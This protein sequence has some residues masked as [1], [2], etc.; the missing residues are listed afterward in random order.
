MVIKKMI[1]LLFLVL[2]NVLNAQVEIL[3]SET[4]SP[5]IYS[6]VAIDSNNDVI[7][8]GSLGNTINI[9]KY[10]TLGELI[11]SNV[12]TNAYDI[13][14]IVT[15]VNNNIY[16]AVSSTSD[17]NIKVLKLTS[18]GEQEWL[19]ES[20]ESDYSWANDIAITINGDVIAI[21]SDNA[22][23]GWAV[24]R[25]D[26]EGNIVW[27]NSYNVL[28]SENTI[29]KSVT[30]DN[31]GKIIIAGIAGD[32]FATLKCDGQGNVIW[33]KEQNFTTVYGS[34]GVTGVVCDSQNNIYAVGS[35]SLDDRMRLVKYNSAGDLLFE[36]S[37]INNYACFDVLLYNDSTI[38]TVGG[39]GEP[40]SGLLTDVMLV[41]F[42]SDGDSL[43]SYQ[44]D[45]NYTDVIY[46]A[47]LDNDNKVIG[48]G[49]AGE[50]NVDTAL[51][52]KLDLDFTV[53]IDE[54]NYELEITNYELKQNYPNPFN[55]VTRINYHLPVE[56]MNASSLQSASIVVYNAS[57]QS[58]WATKISTSQNFVEF[59]GSKLNSGVYY[60]S[61]MIDGKQISTKKMILTK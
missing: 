27:Q 29:A 23:D 59:D 45:V 18:D 44:N 38:V 19:S 58:V 5:G 7:I 39:K 14:N 17:F 34:I 56:T 55:P 36:K 6:G 3:W 33:H 32:Y 35:A 15:D 4:F 50:Q 25:I 28:N 52:M 60:Y 21:G 11:W 13:G 51:L 41:T 1:V 43:F 54:G 61:L 49:Q 22:N 24:I 37:S 26:E 53:D 42:N 31:E 40:D 12:Y 48:I 57:G 47:K 20:F 8:G 30:L 16:I 10:N 46:S 2:I 9:K